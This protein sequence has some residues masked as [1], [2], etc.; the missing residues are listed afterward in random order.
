ME[1]DPNKARRQ[2]FKMDSLEVDEPQDYGS[3][4]S[5]ATS[6]FDTL[7]QMAKERQEHQCSDTER[8]TNFGSPVL[9]KQMPK[10][11]T[12]SE[13]GRRYIH[14]FHHN[15]KP[16]SL[17]DEN[18]KNSGIHSP[19]RRPRLHSMRSESA[20]RADN[21]HNDFVTLHVDTKPHYLDPAS[22]EQ[23]VNPK[24]VLGNG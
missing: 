23:V 4:L 24:P 1:R 16:R 6:D 19:I 9:E 5:L 11:R 18:L 17:D 21:L 2:S 22:N 15:D 14:R 12:R 13:K 7:F 10:R 20:N 8:E 3:N